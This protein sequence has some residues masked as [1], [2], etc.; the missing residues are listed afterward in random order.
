[1]AVGM[2]DRAVQSVNRAMRMMEDFH[3]C[4]SH[5]HVAVMRNTQF[6]ITTSCGQFV[7]AEQ[8]EK[9][10]TEF[11]LLPFSLKALGQWQFEKV[12][13]LLFAWDK[14][15][16]NLQQ[17]KERQFLEI[18]REVIHG[19]LQFLRGNGLYAVK[20][21]SR[22]HEQAEHYY[23][24]QQASYKF[25]QWLQRALSLQTA[26]QGQ[27]FLLALKISLAEA[28]AYIWHFKKAQELCHDGLI[29]AGKFFGNDENT[30][31]ATI[32]YLQAG[33][34]FSKWCL[35]LSDKKSL[36]TGLHCLNESLE[37]FKSVCSHFP[38]PYF[39]LAL[40]LKAV[41]LLEQTIKMQKQV[42]GAEHPET[43]FT[44]LQYE[45]LRKNKRSTYQLS[46]PIVGQM[47]QLSGSDLDQLSQL[48]WLDDF[49]EIDLDRLLLDSAAWQNYAGILANKKR[50]HDARD[51][52]IKSIALKPTMSNL[53]EY[54]LLL[55]KRYDSYQAL[56]VAKQALS[57]LET[58]QW[59]SY[60]EY[61]LHQL[62]K[63]LKKLFAQHRPFLS[64]PAKSLA[65]YIGI[66]SALKLNRI[67]CAK[68]LLQR[69]DR[70]SRTLQDPVSIKLFNVSQR[71]C[72]HRRTGP[73]FFSPAVLIED[74]ISGTLHSSTS[75][76][77]CTN[78]AKNPT[79]FRRQ[80]VSHKALLC[81]NQHPAIL[82]N[83]LGSR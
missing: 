4:Q 79:F 49:C 32:Q 51:A 22:C 1:M 12:F 15:L 80:L 45:Q 82:A 21:L 57:Q 37:N 31:S 50:Y 17:G 9:Q 60:T 5:R 43:Q 68:A 38:H 81:C 62:D 47:L 19:R 18:C 54:A 8:I 69:F 53:A 24:P 7:Q 11:S 40:R 67:S 20:I 6:L 78:L 83:T 61:S 29:L 39:L 76:T 27:A 30:F 59:V 77:C 63:C 46:N 48:A 41:S 64:F 23:L 71:Q 10:I 28:L 26:E 14:L 33:F 70:A 36:T 25:L 16:Q 58:D 35:N 65:Y 55:F 44:Q 2:P 42:Y 56:A 75:P 74:P 52:F 73:S 34:V 66:A 13:S 3:S 72:H